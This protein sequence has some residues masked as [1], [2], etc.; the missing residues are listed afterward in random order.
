MEFC[1]VED[2]SKFKKCVEQGVE[3][4][5][6]LF[7]LF[8][9]SPLPF[10][11]ASQYGVGWFILT[12]FKVRALHLV[13]A[14]FLLFLVIPVVKRE[15]RGRALKLCD[16]VMSC[17]AVCSVGYIFVFYDALL[18]RIAMPNG[19]DVTTAVV[20][21]CLVLEAARRAIGFPIVIVAAVFLLYAAFGYAIPGV[22]AHKGYDIAS[23]VSHEWFTSEGVFGVALGVS[24]NFVFLYVL[25]GSLL[26]KAGAGNFFMK[27]SFALLRGTVGGPAKASVVASGF[28]GM[29]SGSSVANTITI[30]SFTIPL[31]KKM[32]MSPQKAAAIEVSA[33]INGQ[34]TPP[35]MGA[36]AF[37]MSE[38]LAIPYSHIV[39]HALV[40]ALLVYIG[41][42]VIVH[43][44]VCRLDAS[45]G[46]EHG[47]SRG[48]APSYLYTVIKLLLIATSTAFFFMLA[49]VVIDGI[50]V[51]GFHIPGLK[52]ALKS[53]GIYAVVLLLVAV[54]VGILLCKSGTSDAD[55][56]EEKFIAGESGASGWEILKQG[57][58]F[59]IPVC[60]LVWMLVVEKASSA[61][62][63]FW[64]N[65]FLIFMLIVEDAV[66]SL[67][68]RNFDCVLRDLCN[69][70]KKVGSAMT[71][72]SKNM[73]AVAIATATAGIVVG[74]V[75]LTG[76]GPIISALVDTLAGSSV[77]LALLVT[78]VICIV[79]GM[80]MP[81]TGCYI[82]V[83]TLV[84]PALSFM[85]HK[86]GMLTPPVAL[87]LFVLY[88]G[89]MADVTPPVGIASY[90]AAAIAR[91]NSFKTGVQAF[92]YNIKTMM[93]PFM[94]VFNGNIILY[95][96][97]SVVGAVVSILTAL[98]S[99]VSVSAGMQGYFFRRNKLYE[100]VA[101]IMIGIVLMSPDYIASAV[102]ARKVDIVAQDMKD[103]YLTLKRNDS[104]TVH[105]NKFGCE[106]VNAK[107]TYIVIPIVR[108]ASGS[109]RDVLVD[110]GGL[111]LGN[112][113]G[114]Q[115]REVL[116][117]ETDGYVLNYIGA[118]DHVTKL[119]V[120]HR[121]K[122]G[123]YVRVIALL[124][125]CYLAF[126]QVYRESKA[127]RLGRV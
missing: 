46:V 80:G 55:E 11:M 22:L 95:A 108:D 43:L 54:Y 75:G 62:A 123:H 82:I 38:F 37:L 12:G 81:T 58:H 44:E 59:F 6:A 120:L 13:F 5:W 32:G 17:L 9:A 70:A 34:V 23:I 93:V 19:L 69:G 16:W 29:M 2:K 35:V 116:D 26:D 76:F 89:L 78:A 124:A 36:A 105:Y 27:L 90:A 10:L 63:G 51:G 1:N 67:K 52:T 64:T 66:I 73:L 31:M 3:F 110:I 30:G 15:D 87:H 111:V 122:N 42:L 18:E 107:S 121:N 61:L 8:V 118:G 14:L 115:G 106:G 72:S 39:K 126:T 7:Q 47:S 28:M 100:S 65:M 57:L 103:G 119:T 88:F 85:V 77:L 94:F 92:L 20:G 127:S 86:N 79:L 50:T 102:S 40:P 68:K 25:F 56:S 48:I 104:V 97:E 99:I 109:I 24:C 117:V 49:Y 101:L 84:V 71:A 45:R 53:L 91:A 41:L 96:V 113:D 4:L 21:I 98:F 33:G 83:S 74:A 114:E 60:I 112:N 125:L